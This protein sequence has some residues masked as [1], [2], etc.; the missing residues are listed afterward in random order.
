[1]KS[2]LV[3]HIFF[4][5]THV[6][7]KLSTFNRLDGFISS[8][9][10]HISSIIVPNRHDCLLH[11]HVIESCQSFNV[12]GVG[13]QYKCELLSDDLCDLPERDGVLPRDSGSVFF[14]SRKEDCFRFVIVVFLFASTFMGVTCI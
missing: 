12:I 1:M 11:C 10:K 13:S 9:T 5:C 3:L 4:T 14:M 2:I 7:G 6:Q 8:S